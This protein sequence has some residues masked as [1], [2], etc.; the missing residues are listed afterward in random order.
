M[1]PSWM[2]LM[3]LKKKK[4]KDPIELPSPFDYGRTQQEGI[5]YEPDM[6][7]RTMLA[8]WF[9]TSNLQHCEGEKKKSLVYKPP[10]ML[11]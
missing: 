3:F 5:S 6:N 2:G 9:Q 11:L 1:E 4:K 10:G 8:H 7:L